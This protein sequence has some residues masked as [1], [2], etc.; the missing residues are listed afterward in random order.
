MKEDKPKGIVVSDLDLACAQF[1][2]GQTITQK[3]DMLVE[4]PPKI[5]L[6]WSVQ[7]STLSK[8]VAYQ[9]V[10]DSGF[11]GLRGCELGF[12]NMFRDSEPTL[13]YDSCLF[14]QHVSE[15]EVEFSDDDAHEVYQRI[16]KRNQMLEDKVTICGITHIHPRGVAGPS[17]K[18]IDEFE[19]RTKFNAGFQKFYGWVDVTNEFSHTGLKR[20]ISN[21]LETKDAV[22]LSVLGKPRMYTK[23][24]YGYSLFVILPRYSKEY[25]AGIGEYK[26]YTFNIKPSEYRLLGPEDGVRLNVI[27]D[28]S[29]LGSDE[30]TQIAK[31]VK[32]LG[33]VR[34][35]RSFMPMDIL[36]MPIVRSH[37]E[38]VSGIEGS[39]PTTAEE[40]LALL[41]DYLRFDKTSLQ[42]QAIRTVHDL[43]SPIYC[44]GDYQGQ[45]KA[46]TDVLCEISPTYKAAID[47]KNGA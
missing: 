4:T 11:P 30:S 32:R 6:E 21:A 15:G 31:Y 5:P 20:G 1:L 33:F 37:P 12:V 16:E 39:M 47:L 44:R 34:T 28:K 36:S 18:D 46:A 10:M 19:K 8:M 13:F 43:F 27:E 23:V 24:R 2:N 22:V 3:R 25:W 9:I 26:E 42:A 45:I 38:I 17:P 7:R 35:T 14:H 41:K 40:F 29:G